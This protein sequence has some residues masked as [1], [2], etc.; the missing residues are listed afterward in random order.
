MLVS[1]LALFTPAVAKADTRVAVINMKEAI[2]KTNEG[3]TEALRLDAMKKKV[4]SD[5]EGE[6]SRLMHDR[7]DIAKRCNVTSLTDSCKQS[8]E[9]LQRRAMAFDSKI[10]QADQ[11]YKNEE[12]RSTKPLLDR[13][14]LIVERLAKA[15]GYDIV[16]D[17]NAVHFIAKPEADLT[18]RA[19]ST[20]NA[21]SKVPPPK[22][23]P[24]STTKPAPPSKTPPSPKK[25]P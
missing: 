13:M 18:E 11:D 2:S 22:L 9:E 10:S 15:D 20:Y 12:I 7:D 3:A 4:E 19:V 21:E 14:L 24:P 23:P 1:S 8:M 25:K 6:K 17:S 16:L 5:L